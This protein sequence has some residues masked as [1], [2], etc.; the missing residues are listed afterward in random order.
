MGNVTVD[1][2]N[3][4]AGTMFSWLSGQI[5]NIRVWDPDL[6]GGGSRWVFDEWDDGGAIAHDITVGTSD[7]TITANY[8]QQHQPIV[9]LL[10]LDG[11]HG[12]AAHFTSRGFP[13]DQP[14]LSGTWSDWVDNGTALSFDTTGANSN[15]TERWITQA[16][17][18]IAPWDSVTAAFT[19]N[20]SYWHQVTPTVIIQGLPLFLYVPISFTVFGSV[21]T[22]STATAWTDWVDYGSAV[23]VGGRVDVPPSTRYINLISTGAT[24][25]QFTIT[26]ARTIV[27]PFM[28]QFR[29]TVCLIGTNPEHTVDV[30]FN[31][32]TANPVLRVAINV[33]GMW[34]DWAD[35][36]SFTVFSSNTSGIPP[37]RAINATQLLVDSAFSTCIIY[38]PPP[39]N[40]T[41]PNYKPL[42]SLAFV[43]LLLILGLLWGNRKPWD[44]HIPDPLHPMKPEELA[45]READLRKMPIVDKFK[46]LSL[47]ELEEKFAKD[48]HWTMATLAMPFAVVEGIIGIASLATGILKVP[49]SGNWLSAGLIVNT[50]LLLAGIIYS[51]FMQ[52]RG[53]RVPSDAELASLKT[54]DEPKEV[55]LATDGKNKP[56]GGVAAEN[57]G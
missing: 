1:G 44:R 52:S 26:S 6:V 8:S 33:S 32:S 43:A 21:R 56:K 7:R 29:P 45:K 50:L 46:V 36:G 30:R 13:V 10:G 4:T 14:G 11:L 40:N 34:T 20:V 37:R 17:F 2:F 23:S 22:S 31:D 27:V 12:V 35:D 39:P 48:R 25:L 51:A 9:N 19:R 3:Y 15:A 49:D 38:E 28:A 47:A 24:S 53:Y 54:E 41:E 57:G 42:I 16:M 18:N 55:G 5:H